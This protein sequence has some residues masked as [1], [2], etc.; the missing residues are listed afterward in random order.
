M[1]L[2]FKKYGETGEPLLILH[3]LFGML[4]NWATLGRKFA[5]HFQ[6]YL[7]DQRNHG[8]S[9][10]NSEMNYELMADDLVEFIQQQQLDKVNVI[11]H[12]MGGK[13]AMQLA[14][15]YPHLTKKLIVADIAPK[16]YL[17]NH[18]DIFE[19]IESLNLNEIESR[20]QADEALTPL[21]PNFG[22]R[23]FILKNLARS[24]EGNYFWRPA[25]QYI[26]TNYSN[27][28]TSIDG[29]F[30]GTT[31]F[32]R[33]NKSN[34]ILDENWPEIKSRF[35]NATLIDIEDAGHWVHAEKPNEFYK[36]V[37]NFLLF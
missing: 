21:L 33:G 30:N 23:Q 14:V 17:G 20:K 13:V 15:A 19:A 34:Y 32:L 4:D 9:S 10:H 6:V 25:I 7:I 5:Q 18:N 8:R 24:N 11:G 36:A 26:K 27:I 1:E 22:V 3:G 16:A 37:T 31:L 2:N 12:S 29:S 35:P 28:A